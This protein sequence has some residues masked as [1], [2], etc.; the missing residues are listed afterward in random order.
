MYFNFSLSIFIYISSTIRSQLLSTP[1]PEQSS[2]LSRTPVRWVWAEEAA[3]Q[4]SFVEVV[5][6]QTG[7]FPDHPDMSRKM[8]TFGA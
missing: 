5:G 8:K 6:S 1:D 4:H 3:L 7:E 2:S